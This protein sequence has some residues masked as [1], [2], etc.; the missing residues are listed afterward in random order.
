MVGILKFPEDLFDGNIEVGYNDFGIQFRE[1]G[2][3]VLVL[4]KQNAIKLKEWLN[5]IFV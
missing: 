3:P 1:S 2:E 5:E 4:T